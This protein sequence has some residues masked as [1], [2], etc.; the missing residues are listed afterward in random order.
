MSK[1]KQNNMLVAPTVLVVEKHQSNRHGTE[2]EKQECKK[3]I[4]P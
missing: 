4:F 3:P 1:I 2:S